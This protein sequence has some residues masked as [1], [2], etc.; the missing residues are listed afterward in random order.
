MIMGQR[1][2][3]LRGHGLVVMM[4]RDM[5]LLIGSGLRSWLAAVMDIIVWDPP[6]KLSWIV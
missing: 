3:S 1:G 5:G 2:G 6:V 4:I